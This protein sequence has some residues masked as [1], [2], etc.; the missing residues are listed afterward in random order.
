MSI[1]WLIRK[2]ESGENRLE[3]E[4]QNFWKWEKDKAGWR[5]GSSRPTCV[6]RQ[7]LFCLG[8]S[9]VVQ[10]LRLHDPNAEDLGLIPGQEARSHMPQLKIPHAT[11]KT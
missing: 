3:E 5:P 9:L 4:K 1:K 11:I 2:K 6:S 10:C 7:N 8:T